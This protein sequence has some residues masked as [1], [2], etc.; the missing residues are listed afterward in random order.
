M[1]LLAQWFYLL[2]LLVGLLLYDFSSTKRGSQ[3]RATGWL[4]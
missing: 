3:L 1:N 4:A 2:V